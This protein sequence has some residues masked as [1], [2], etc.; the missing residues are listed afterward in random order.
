MTVAFHPNGMDVVTGSAD[1][2]ARIWKMPPDPRPLEDFVLLAKL[3]A[4]GWFDD[5]GNFVPLE[6]AAL[7][8]V[9]LKVRGR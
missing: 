2:S 9:W 4:G 8:A 1:K 6:P 3:L 7:K 5:T